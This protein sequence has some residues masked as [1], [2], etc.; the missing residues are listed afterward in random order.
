VH[1]K[2][3]AVSCRD[4]GGVLTAML[5]EQQAVI[6]Q[7][8]DGGVGNYAYDAAHGM[9]FKGTKFVMASGACDEGR[10]VM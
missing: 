4:A 8:I 1:V 3:A 2:I 6:D 10:E 7:L 5:Q 9:S